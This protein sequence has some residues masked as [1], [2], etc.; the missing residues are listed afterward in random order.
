MTVL[1]LPNW[2]NQQAGGGA[3]LSGSKEEEAGNKR[4][5]LMSTGSVIGTVIWGQNCD[6]IIEFC[7]R[8]RVAPDTT[9]VPLYFLAM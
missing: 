5:M 1:V 3:Y 7:P 9:N 4:G 8:T 2:S 6:F